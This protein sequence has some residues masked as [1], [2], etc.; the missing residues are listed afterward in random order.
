MLAQ[1]LAAGRALF[2]LGA[3]HDI[4]TIDLHRIANQVLFG[5]PAQD[6][7]GTKV[8]PRHV[9]AA[10]D[11]VVRLYARVVEKVIRVRASTRKGVPNTLMPHYRNFDTIHRKDTDKPVLEVRYRP[12]AMKGSHASG[13]P[14]GATV[15]R[16]AVRPPLWY[17]WIYRF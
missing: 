14:Q 17:C 2:W 15:V 6:A 16:V 7:T 12:D 9:R 11:A 13:V 1:Q 5:R 3:D 8:E 10:E 4:V